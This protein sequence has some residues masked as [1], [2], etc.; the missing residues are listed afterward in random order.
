VIL[1]GLTRRLKRGAKEYRGKTA[2]KESQV[3]TDYPPEAPVWKRPI[4]EPGLL[5]CSD[6][7]GLPWIDARRIQGIAWVD[8][9]DRGFPPRPMLVDILPVLS[10]RELHV[11]FTRGRRAYNDRYVNRKCH[12]SINMALRALHEREP[13]SS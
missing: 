6:K 13:M 5:P 1:R 7:C 8:P 2:E 9:N 11:G 3:V 10:A 12:A 4:E